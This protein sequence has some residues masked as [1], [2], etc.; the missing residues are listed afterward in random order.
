MYKPNFPTAGWKMK[1]GKSKVCVIF[2]SGKPNLYL[3]L[4]NAADRHI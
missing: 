4:R 1:G 2:V 3:I